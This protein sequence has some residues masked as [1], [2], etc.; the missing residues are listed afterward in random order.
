MTKDDFKIMYSDIMYAFQCIEFDLKRIYSGMAAADFDECMD[1]L[2]TSNLGNVL[3]RLKALD[4]SD[5]NPYLKDED[6]ELLDKIREIRNYWCH[7][8]YTEFTYIQN[9]RDREIKFQKVG[10]RLVNDY[11]RVRKLQIK[12][13]KFYFNNFV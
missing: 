13:Q 6:Y 5:G 9:D 10:R 11:N 7:K 8:C 1:M 3:K 12:L 4:N 2:E